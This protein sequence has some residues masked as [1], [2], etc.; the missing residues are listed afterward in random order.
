[1][2]IFIKVKP[3]IFILDKRKGNFIFRTRY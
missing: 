1:M 2:C 3:K